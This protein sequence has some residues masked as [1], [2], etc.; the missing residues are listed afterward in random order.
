MPFARFT[1]FALTLLLATT[2]W[3]APL[4]LCYDEAPQPPWT[5]PDET[6]LNIELLKRTEKQLGEQFVF[7]AKPWKRCLEEARNGLVDGII[8]AADAVDRRDYATLPQLPNGQG[9]PEQALYNDYYLVFIRKGSGAS[10]NGRQFVNLKGDVVAQRGYIV[11]DDLRQRGH[12]VRDSIKIPDEGLRMLAAGAADAAV[13]LGVDGEEKL[14]ANPVYQ[15]R[16]EQAKLIFSAVPLYLMISRKT[17]E[18]DPHRINR[19]WQG[20]RT[21]RASPAYRKLEESGSKVR[22]SHKG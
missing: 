14:A 22:Q 8:G 16:I 2:A 6:G 1:V 7:T 19:V 12:R 18:V 20:I 5:M 3:C 10:W 11:V 15:S 13:L 17:Y 4:K 9:D 21:V